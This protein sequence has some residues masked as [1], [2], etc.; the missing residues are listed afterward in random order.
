MKKLNHDGS[1]LYDAIELTINPVDKT[2][3][4][5]INTIDTLEQ[6]D[7]SVPSNVYCKTDIYIYIYIY[8]YMYIYIYIYIGLNFKA[9]QSYIFTI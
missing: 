9:E 6:L 3:K 1:T 7:N 2:I 8:I 5:N 4:L